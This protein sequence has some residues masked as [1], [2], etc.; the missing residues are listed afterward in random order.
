MQEPFHLRM[1]LQRR[2]YANSA[3]LNPLAKAQASISRLTTL[4]LGLY[5]SHHI[6]FPFNEPPR[7][8]LLPGL[9]IGAGG[10]EKHEDVVGLDQAIT[11]CCQ[12]HDGVR[13]YNIS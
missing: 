6:V 10:L 13:I 12:S 2:R 9:R 3:R 8:R 1:R 5:P 11:N 4:H 7:A